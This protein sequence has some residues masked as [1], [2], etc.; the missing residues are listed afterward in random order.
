MFITDLD[1]LT[2][3]LKR[4]V[5]FQKDMNELMCPDIMYLPYSCLCYFAS[6]NWFRSKNEQVYSKICFLLC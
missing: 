4:I 5:N 3:L 2:D 1:V 6:F